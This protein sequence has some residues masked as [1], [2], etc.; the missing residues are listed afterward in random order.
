LVLPDTSAVRLSFYNGFLLDAL[1]DWEWLFELPPG[2]RLRTLG[3]P[4]ARDR[5]AAGAR[6]PEA[7]A[8]YYVVDW[9]G[10]TIGQTFGS[11]NVGLAGRT[12][13]D[14]ASDRGVDPFDALLDIVVADDLRT[15]IVTQ[16]RGNDAESWKLREA[17][18]RDPRTIPGGSDSGAHLDM[19]DTFTM[20]TRLLG[21][22]VRDRHMLTL[23]EAVHLLTAVPAGLYGLKGRGV[24]REGAWADLFLFDPATV[25]AG[26][27]H[28]RYDLPGGAPRLY[29]EA[30]GVHHVMVAGVEIVSGT[31]TTGKLPG[32]TI[33]SGRDTTTV[34]AAEARTA[35]WRHI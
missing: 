1:P 12:V 10:L 8:L 28:L 7:Q 2:P 32:R 22:Q 11:A 5:L 27:V 6:R 17:T 18:V 21:P 15:L 23:E 3:D 24:I 14:I 35:A 31:E 20:A 26:P 13:G 16:L 30:V 33:R 9:A 29:G 19:L 34:T 25:D 4:A